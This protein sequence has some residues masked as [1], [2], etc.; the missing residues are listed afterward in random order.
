MHFWPSRSHVP[1][2][3]PAQPAHDDDPL[4]GWTGRALATKLLRPAIFV[5]IYASLAASAW[6]LSATA[7][8]IGYTALV[9]LVLREFYVLVALRSRLLRGVGLAA[10]ALLL[11]QPVI[12]PAWPETLILSAAWIFCFA[13]M[14]LSTAR[15]DRGE[16]HDL[17]LMI[18]GVL[19]VSLTLGQLVAI[20][21]LDAGRAWTAVVVLT[22]AARES[23]AALGG[24][25]L[26][27]APMINEPVSPRKTYAGWLAGTLASLTA[28]VVLTRAFDLAVTVGQ[29]TIFGLWMGAAC[30]LGDL[31]E[32]YL[33]RMMGQRHSGTALGPQGG[34]LDTTDALAF[35]A[36]VAHGLLHVWGA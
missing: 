24:I 33:K 11:L 36:V 8:I 9:L 35:A 3:Q 34:L 32:S 26:P 21:Y 16:L 14:T 28:A 6:R 22:V 10:S 18:C 5:G 2:A 1:P 15:P 27:G 23:G 12:A 30:Q 31:A 20:R 4:A 19:S 13:I 25:A 29:A 17:L 7:W